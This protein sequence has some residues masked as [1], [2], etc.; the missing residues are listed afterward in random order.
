[1]EGKQGFLNKKFIFTCIIPIC[2]C[3][4]CSYHQRQQ[5]PVVNEPDGKTVN[6]TVRAELDGTWQA[7]VPPPLQVE[8]P[9]VQ[10]EAPLGLEQPLRQLLHHH[11][12]RGLELSR[13]QE[14]PP[15]NRVDP[16]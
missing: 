9:Q 6:N 5:R 4:T 3:N 1:M 15:K 8:G 10:G 11:L 16:T 14:E 2:C 13:G 12:T 7:V